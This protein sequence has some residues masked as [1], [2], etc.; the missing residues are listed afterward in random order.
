MGGKGLIAKIGRADSAQSRGAS[1]RAASNPKATPVMDTANYGGSPS[2][3]VPIAATVAHQER[4]ADT[5][6]VESTP[7]RLCDSR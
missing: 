5:L 3:R 1:G 6:D 2:A 4:I 7:P